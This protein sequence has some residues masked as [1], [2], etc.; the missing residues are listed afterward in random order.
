ML[1][2]CASVGRARGTCELLQSFSVELSSATE[3][4]VVYSAG[5]EPAESAPL[6]VS[7]VKVAVDAYATVA[8]SATARVAGGGNAITE[9]V[10]VASWPFESCTT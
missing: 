6:P 4:C 8:V 10:L 2:L 3:P 5:I 1:Q 7:G 9:T